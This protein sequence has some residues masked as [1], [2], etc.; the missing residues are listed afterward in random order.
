MN[1][2]MFF[3]LIFLLCF[4]KPQLSSGQSEIRFFSGLGISEDVNYNIGLDYS[5]N[6]FF[7]KE[8]K[9]N[10]GTHAGVY[11]NKF[12]EPLLATEKQLY[13]RLGLQI[14]YRLL[15][16]IWIRGDLGSHRPINKK[17][18]FFNDS[19]GTHIPNTDLGSHNYISSSAEYCINE[20]LSCL[21]LYNIAFEDMLD[22][23]AFCIGV[24]VNL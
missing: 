3:L 20:T 4:L 23:D 10:F 14:K 2:S 11:Y 9:F 21:I 1:K 13:F 22:L 17:K 16:K 5:F 7:S 15:K 12:N 18:Y 8:S 19:M 24:V 6:F